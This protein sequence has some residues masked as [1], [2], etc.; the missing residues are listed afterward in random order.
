[1]EQESGNGTPED[2]LRERRLRLRWRENEEL[3]TLYANHVYVSHAGNEFYLV[4]GE[5]VPPNIADESDFETLPEYLDITPVARIAIAPD[6][7]LKI[8]GAISSN[9]EA[10]M[11]KTG[12]LE[13]E[14]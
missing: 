2:D 13:D 11:G 8:V 5:V 12:L 1:M 3:T 6:A 9:V 14:S 10:Y 4:F 7:M